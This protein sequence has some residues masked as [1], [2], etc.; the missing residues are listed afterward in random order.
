MSR[1]SILYHLF[2]FAIYVMLQVFLFDNMVL[3][4]TAF[5]FVYTG[6][7]LLLPLEISTVALIGLGFI[8]GF[9]IDIFYNSLG[10]NAASTTLIAFTRPYWLS[11]ITPGGGYED[12][13]LPSLKSLGFSWFITY[14][15]PLI[16]LHHFS[17]FIIEAGGF[18][19]FWLIF[20]KAFFSSLYTFAIL[21]IGQNLFYNRDRLS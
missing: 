15:L 3:F 8:T 9:S 2:I 5:C 21:V 14:A 17:L 7:I 19:H 12:V 18:F 16:M 13:R 20:K 6:F 4:G 1:Q 10:I 11:T